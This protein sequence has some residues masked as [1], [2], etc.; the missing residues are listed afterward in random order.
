MNF[1]YLSLKNHWHRSQNQSPQKKE[2]SWWNLRKKLEENKQ[3]VTKIQQNCQNKVDN[4]SSK[5]GINLRSKSL[6]LTLIF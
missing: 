3:L 2:Q 1:F 6:I 5:P 4:A